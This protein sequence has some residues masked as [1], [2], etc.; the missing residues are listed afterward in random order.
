M[1]FIVGIEEPYEI[2]EISKSKVGSTGM[3]KMRMAMPGANAST[4]AKNASVDI[5]NQINIVMY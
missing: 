5:E 1:D 4:V 2:V 3:A